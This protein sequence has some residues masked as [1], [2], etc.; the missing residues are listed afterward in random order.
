VALLR[1]INLG[2]HK[3]IA[4]ADLRRVYADAGCDSVRTVIASGNVLF[5]HASGD[6]RQLAAL[7]ERAVESELGVSAPVVLRSFAELGKLVQAHPFGDDTSQTYVTFLPKKPAAAAVRA[8]R[9]LDVAPE[10]V[11]VVG[12]DVF[13]RYP[14]GVRNARVSVTLLDRTLG[15]RGTNRNWRTVTKLAELATA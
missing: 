4:M 2:P 13:V 10:E 11:A 12:S 9:E 3:R 7:L 5:E 1:G 15:I 6:R 8:L 14:N